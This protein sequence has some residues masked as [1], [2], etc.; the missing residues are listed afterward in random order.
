LFACS[1]LAVGGAERQWSL[2]VP[3]LRSRFDVSVLTLVTEGPFFEELRVRG[4]PV[5]CA[6]MRR[7]TDLR[8]VKRAL[9]LAALRPKLVV[10]HS[11]NADV[12][13]HLI[14]R[15]AGAAH[16][17]N[18]HFNVG[19]GA[20][21]RLHRRLLGRLVG[22]RVDSAI[23]IANVQVPRLVELG[24]HPDKV[25]VIYN[26]VAGPV[27]AESRSHVREKLGV[28]GDEF[29]ALLVATLRPEK[30]AHVFLEAVREAHRTDPRIRGL[31]VGGGPELGPLKELAGGDGVVQV[32]GQRL[33]VP[34][35]L[36]AADVGCLSSAAEGI[37]M[38]LLEAMA[39]GK[40]VLA[41]DVGGVAEAVIAERTGILVPVGDRLAYAEAL[42]RLA[43]NP[44]FAH[45][46]GEAGRERHRRVFSLQRMIAE[47]ER[48]FEE[49][50]NER[51]TVSTRL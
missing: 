43:S 34:D 1:T 36:G 8:G 37:P 33:D 5:F 30:E 22:P 2:L 15:R 19:P 23:A 38:S 40:P 42:R 13:G 44:N 28:R 3:A 11:I 14:A 41:T 31:I 6:H 17:T 4:I 49:I 18:E 21:T 47:Y 32:L 20:P 35:L 50:L 29:L 7:R 26:G 45:R 24:Y 51:A 48:A 10:T 39:L 16:V 27:P 12:V 46:L 9:R 25:R